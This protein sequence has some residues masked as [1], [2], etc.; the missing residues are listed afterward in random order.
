MVDRQK[1]QKICF[2]CFMFKVPRRAIRKTAEHMRL[3]FWGE[4]WTED[5]NLGGV[6]IEAIVICA[7][8][9]R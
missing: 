6:R 9:T 8:G 1:A 7:H 3:K 5:M 2:E 4:I